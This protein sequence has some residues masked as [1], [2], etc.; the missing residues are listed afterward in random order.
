MDT[1]NDKKQGGHRSAS[2][3]THMKNTERFDVPTD[4]ISWR[5]PLVWARTNSSRDVYRQ[6]L[7]LR[8][9]EVGGTRSFFCGFCLLVWLV[10]RGWPSR[11]HFATRAQR[12]S[13][14]TR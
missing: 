6:D 3:S 13:E 14:K 7:S 2:A 4:E 10:L 5:R 1:S 12:I 11:S 8:W 9:I